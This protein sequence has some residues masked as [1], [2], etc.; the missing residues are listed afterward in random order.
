MSSQQPSQAP[1]AAPETELTAT[2]ATAPA[3]VP[4]ATPAAAST[5]TPSE[6]TTGNEATVPVDEKHNSK[7]MMHFGPANRGSNVPS[8]DFI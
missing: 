4:A 2:P 3:A 5:A 1:A 6:A 8:L 7:N